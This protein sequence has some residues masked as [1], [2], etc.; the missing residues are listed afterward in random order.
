MMWAYPG[1][2]LLFMGQEFGQGQEWNFRQSLDWHLLE[3]GWHRG[4][5]ALVRN[6]NEAYRA[7]PALHRNDCEDAGFGWAVVDDREQS[8]FCLLYTSRCV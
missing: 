1:K 4:T 2:K 3:I 6:C 8:V 5:Q 7:H